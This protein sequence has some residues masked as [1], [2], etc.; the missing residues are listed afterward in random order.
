MGSKKINNIFIK[1]GVAYL[2]CAFGLVELNIE[3]AEIRDTYY[4]ID[5]GIYLFMKTLHRIY[6]VT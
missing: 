2:A 1:D 5:N 3:D 4:F 6:L